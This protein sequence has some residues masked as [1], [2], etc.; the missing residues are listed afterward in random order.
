MP[1]WTISQTP[2]VRVSAS[3]IPAA[4]GA[5]AMDVTTAS[6]NVA[7]SRAPLGSHLRGNDPLDRE[8]RQNLRWYVHAPTLRT[9]K[10][11]L[12]V[13]V[14]RGAARAEEPS[15]RRGRRRPGVGRRAG[16]DHFEAVAA[17]RGR[18]DGAASGGVELADERRIGAHDRRAVGADAREANQRAVGRQRDRRRA[19]AFY[20]VDV[21]H[22]RRAGARE[23][24]LEG[25]REKQ[26]RRDL[27]IRKESMPGREANGANLLLSRLAPNNL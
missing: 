23:E 13:W 26:R 15:R 21:V 2:S 24:A 1:P 3:F 19:L 16:C 12:D 7:K 11:R 27:A 9:K 25:P 18:R 17:P 8:I 10:T 6:R 14:P 5:N 22:R 4:S 20:R